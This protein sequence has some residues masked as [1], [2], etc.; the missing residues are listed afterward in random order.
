MPLNGDLD[1]SRF[2][3]LFSYRF[4]L[5]LVFRIVD[6]ILAEGAE[7]ILRFALALIKHN[8]EKIVK[9][10]FEPLLEFL[11]TGLFDLYA[12]DPNRLVSDATEI[13][14]S[15]QKLDQWTNVF[16][17]KLRKESPDYLEAESLKSENRRIQEEVKRLHRDQEQL[18]KEH[19][20]L[21]RELM[22]E[23]QKNESLSD[24]VEVLEE[25]VAALKSVLSSDRNHAE[26]QVRDEMDEL[27]QKNINLTT[28]NA[29][30]QDQVSEFQDELTGMKKEVQEKE[31]V[32]AELTLKLNKLKSALGSI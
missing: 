24:R 19:I 8:S 7:S 12:D 11:K 1:S 20:D 27:A 13:R 9:L 5:D 23:K 30:L 22:E 3:T 16:Y 25:Q 26:E 14:I 29:H 2:M 31:A 10:D 28:A 6:I 21:A 17:D 18:N 32:I 4:P 15:K